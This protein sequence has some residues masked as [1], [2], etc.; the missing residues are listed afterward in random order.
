MK[1]RMRLI[2]LFTAASVW[3][4]ASASSA[5]PVANAC[6]VTIVGN[7]SGGT[8]GNDV[9]DVV[10]ASPDGKI[11]FEPGGPGYVMKDGALSW[12]FGWGRKRPGRLTITGR[13]LDGDAP[14]MRASIPEGYGDIG[15][16]VTA[17]VFPMPGCWEVTGHLGSGSLTFV[18]LVELVG[19]GPA[20]RGDW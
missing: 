8:Y 4:C 7:G 9:L 18:I 11:V 6:P 15:L 16:Q 14:P 12:K 20:G 17:L 1:H 2:T 3:F 19:E 5:T 13:R 10:L